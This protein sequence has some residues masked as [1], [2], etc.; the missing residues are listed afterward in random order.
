MKLHRLSASIF[1]D[2]DLLQDMIFKINTLQLDVI[3]VKNYY[4]LTNKVTLLI[5][6]EKLLS[7]TLC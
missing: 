4:I 7:T 2:K 1:Q 3:M 5:I 6:K